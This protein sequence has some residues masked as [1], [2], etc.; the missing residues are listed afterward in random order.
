MSSVRMRVASKDWCASRSTRSVICTW[1]TADVPVLLRRRPSRFEAQ[2]SKAAIR[3][4]R[5]SP[6]SDDVVKVSALGGCIRGRIVLAVE[7]PGW[8]RGRDLCCRPGE[9]EVRADVLEHITSKPSPYACER[10]RSAWD[11]GF[12]EGVH[13]LPAARTTPPCSWA[14]P[15]TKPGVSTNTSSGRLKASQNRT[16]RAPLRR[17][18][19]PTYRRDGRADSHHAHHPPSNGR[20]RP[21]SSFAQPGLSSKKLAGVDHPGDHSSHVVGLVGIGGDERRNSSSDPPGAPAL[22]HRGLS[23]SVLREIGQ[24]PANRRQALGLIIHG[25]MRDTALLGVS[26]APESSSSST[27]VSPHPR[28]PDRPG[29]GGSRL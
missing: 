2:A 13:Q 6:G 23:S 9:D 4:A 26:R 14:L 25:Q 21:P 29:A 8:R 22:R 18:P 17:R 3:R 1:F 5:V 28:G 15:P 10:R 19:H 27:P 20:S 12:A 24:Q 16:K 7:S 11:R